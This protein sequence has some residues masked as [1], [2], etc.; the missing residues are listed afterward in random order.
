MI[1]DVCVERKRP[2]LS[3]RERKCC[4]RARACG[5]K[6]HLLC[7][8]RL[9][10]DARTPRTEMLSMLQYRIMR[11]RNNKL[12]LPYARLTPTAPSHAA[13]RTLAGVFN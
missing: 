6:T 4:V 13:F 3:G 8:A 10:R 12:H 5:A 2:G 7:G 9:A 11:A 1:C